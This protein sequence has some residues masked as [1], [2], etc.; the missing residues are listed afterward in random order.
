MIRVFIE[1]EIAGL[2]LKRAPKHEQGSGNF[3]A[4]LIQ[5]APRNDKPSAK[6]RL[7]PNS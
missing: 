4:N 7:A 6:L 2:I 1:K 3:S 5:L